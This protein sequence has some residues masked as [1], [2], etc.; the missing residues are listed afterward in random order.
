[1]SRSLD[2]SRAFGFRRFR[3]VPYRKRLLAKCH[4][5]LAR[6]PTV[7]SEQGQA[8]GPAA[9]PDQGRITLANRRARIPSRRF[10]GPVKTVGPVLAEVVPRNAIEKDV[11]AL[12]KQTAK[13]LSQLEASG[14]P[15]RSE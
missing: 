1:M 14:V 4:V 7:E 13:D 5:F 3:C 11:R 6:G 12:G 10:G 9:H 8:S 15:R 2:H